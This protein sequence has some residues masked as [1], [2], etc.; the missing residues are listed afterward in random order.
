V[1]SWFGRFDEERASYNL[2]SRRGLAATT[3]Q[4]RHKP[5]RDDKIPDLC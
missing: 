2:Q 5:G 4:A 1:S 3:W